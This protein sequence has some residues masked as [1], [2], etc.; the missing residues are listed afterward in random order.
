MKGRTGRK[1]WAALFVVVSC[2]QYSGY[3]FAQADSISSVIHWTRLKV[4][5]LESQ[6]IDTILCYHIECVDCDNKKP[7]NPCSIYDERYLFWR[8]KGRNFACSINKCGAHKFTPMDDSTR[9]IIAND[10]VEIIK[11]DNSHTFT[12][13]ASSGVDQMMVI[14]AADNIPKDIFEL[15]ANGHHI[16]LSINNDY[17]NQVLAKDINLSEPEKRKIDEIKDLILDFMIENYKA[18]D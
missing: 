18:E 5:S 11:L 1:Y 12:G 16:L 10:V 13:S 7:K 17:F 2:M 3:C 9:T 4:Q 15:Y 14:P 8:K 6:H